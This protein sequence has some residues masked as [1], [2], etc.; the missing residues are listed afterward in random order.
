[1][2][3]QIRFFQYCKTSGLTGFHIICKYLS[4][5][6]QIMYWNSKRKPEKLEKPKNLSWRVFPKNGFE[7]AQQ[8]EMISTINNITFFSC[9][10]TFFFFCGKTRKSLDNCF[11]QK[12][13]IGFIWFGF[14]LEMVLTLT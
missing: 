8:C 13:I 11:N 2:I 14:G 4:E 10:F 12:F 5:T 7:A 6:N 9:F 3:S 1:M